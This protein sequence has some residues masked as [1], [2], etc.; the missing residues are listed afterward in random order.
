MSRDA[1]SYDPQDIRDT[2]PRPSPRRLPAAVPDGR[3]VGGRTP[4]RSAVPEAG[5]PHF[6]IAERDDSSRGCSVRGRSYSLRDSETHSLTEIGKFRVVAATDLAQ[7]AYQGDRDRM[8]KDV[9]H[10]KSRS[11]L[12]EKTIEVSQKKL[13]RVVT[14]TKGGHRLLRKTNRI[15]S[16]QAIYHGLCRPREVKHDADLYRLYQKE[17]ARIE[18]AGGHPLRVLLDYELNKD[19][20]RDL[21]LLGPHQDTETRKHEIAEKHGLQLVNGKIPVPDL[22]I[23]YESADL[24]IRH[25]DLEPATREYRPKALLEKAAAGFSLYSRP[26]DASRLRRILADRKFAKGI[27]TL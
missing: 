9:R 14:L 23:E 19:L 11:L 7:Y 15:P 27:L 10:L 5:T 6:L 3:S 8:E 26:E 17:A 20:N 24:E 13:L 25:V 18:Q 12:N 2:T 22:R 1:F 16:D 21:A 4:D